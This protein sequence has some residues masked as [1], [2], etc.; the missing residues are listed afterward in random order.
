[1]RYL[2]G[3]YKKEVVEKKYLQATF[4]RHLA[5]EYKDK[6]KIQLKSLFGSTDLKVV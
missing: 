2:D 1:M 4:M 5:A 3:K 6:S